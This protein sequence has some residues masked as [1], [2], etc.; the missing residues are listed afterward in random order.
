VLASICSRD[1]RYEEA[2]SLFRRALAIREKRFGP[3]HTFVAETLE[4]LAKVCDQTGRTAEAQELSARA[5]RIR[6]QAAGEKAV[7]PQEPR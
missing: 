6:A 5:K 1:G 3:D 7:D 2:E 4:G